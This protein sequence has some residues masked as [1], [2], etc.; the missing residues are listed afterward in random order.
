MPAKHYVKR[1]ITETEYRE[2]FDV[3]IFRIQVLG[4]GILGNF[5]EKFDQIV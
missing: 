4:G 2:W 3:K 5:K 1:Y